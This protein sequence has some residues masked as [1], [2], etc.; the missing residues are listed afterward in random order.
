MGKGK[1]KAAPIV[2]NLPHCLAL[3]PNS[4]WSAIEKDLDAK[5]SIDPKVQALRRYLISGATECPIDGPGRINVPPYLREHAGL[6]REV[7][8]AGVGPYIE[9]WNKARFD[10]AISFVGNHYDEISAQVASFTT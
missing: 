1:N 4:E 6:D 8:I 10:E 7:T 2:T 9:I 5:P 3:Y